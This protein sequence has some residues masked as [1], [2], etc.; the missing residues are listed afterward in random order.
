MNGDVPAFSLEFSHHAW[1]RGDPIA[2]AAWTLDTAEAADRAGI[3]AIFASED[4][5]GWDAF[6]VLGAIAARTRQ[7]WLGPGV[8][9]P[10]MRHPNLLAASVATLD[11]LSG[12]RA[13]LG[14][15]RGQ[16]EWYE[17]A[18][19]FPTG[20]PLA[21]LAE[22][23]GLVRAWWA[24]SHRASSPPGGQFA[25]HD[26][27]RQIAPVQARPRIV[28]AAAGPKALALA[29]RVADGVIFNSLTSDAFL[30][31]T[32]PE[33]RTMAIAAGRDPAAFWF[34]LRTTVVVTDR[35]EPELE[36]S[37]ASIALINTLPGMQRL[38][39]TPGFDT[40]AIVAEARRRLDVD[41]QLAEGHG[42]VDLR[43]GNLAGAKA[44]IPDALVK[45]LAIVGDLATVRRRLRRLAALGVTHVSVAPPKDP[46]VTAWEA[47]LGGL[48]GE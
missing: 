43:Q 2:T 33:V 39:R 34:L 8:S 24:P 11:R 35:P 47:L 25:V 46:T 41:R 31:K 3:A 4:P 44:A 30:A 48:R 16:P 36:Q 12:G 15:G 23:I 38:I 14:L 42:F 1:L 28:V 21:R 7:A 10:Y 6:A 45:E 19:G 9:N 32:I 26:W 13:V 40:D 18:L 37:K 20:D 27:A 22:A 29:A 17:R 5:D